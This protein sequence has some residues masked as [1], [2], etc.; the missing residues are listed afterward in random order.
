MEQV[1][2]NL[3]RVLKTVPE[4]AQQIVASNR[5]LKKGLSLKEAEA[6]KLKFERVGVSID[7]QRNDPQQ[8]I[9]TSNLELEPMDEPEPEVEEVPPPQVSQPEQTDVITCPKCDHQQAKAEQCANCGIFFHKLQPPVDDSVA[10]DPV[11]VDQEF[12]QEDS[13][14]DSLQPKAIAAAAGAALLGAMLWNFIAVAFE[15]ELGLVAWGIGGAVGFAAAAVGSRGQLAGIVCGVLVVMSIMGGKYMAYGTFQ[16][17]AAAIITEMQNEAGEEMRA[18]FDEEMYDAQVFAATVSDETSLREFMVE[19]GYSYAMDPA[20][21]DSDEIDAFN[22][23]NRPRLTRF[24]S[25]PPTFGEWI[26][27]AFDEID[28]I[29]T[30]GLVMDSFG[31][32]D[33][34]F[35]FFGVGT[36]FRLGSRHEAG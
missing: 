19:N 22:E 8:F 12:D 34:L 33:L 23:Y 26:S 3:A 11:D 24:A 27:G 9:P 21:V 17:Q 15:Y 36:A 18:V 35:L 30:M 10:N 16:E 14:E 5:V 32:L 13:E 20:S 4:K 29:S 31:V 28:D 7:I 2:E 6:F 25:N 1:G